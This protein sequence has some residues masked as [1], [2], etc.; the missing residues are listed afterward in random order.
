MTVAS[1]PTPLLNLY[2]VPMLDHSE[3]R[4]SAEIITHWWRNDLQL[5]FSAWTTVDSFRKKNIISSW[6]NDLELRCTGDPCTVFCAI[7]YEENVWCSCSFLTYICTQLLM[8]VIFRILN[9]IH[10]YPPLS[11]TTYAKYSLR[12]EK[13]YN[14]SIFSLTSW[15]LDYEWMNFCNSKR[16]PLCT[17]FHFW[18][19]SWYRWLSEGIR[20]V[21]EEQLYFY[22]PFY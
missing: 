1:I 19:Y 18:H 15:S 20:V 8:K 11:K 10:N 21:Q 9:F 2:S 14:S 22:S 16:Q 4:T 13:K 6:R 5:S 3:V 17:S 12:L 7:K